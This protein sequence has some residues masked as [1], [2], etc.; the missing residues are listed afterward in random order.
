[1]IENEN[2][3]TLWTVLGFLFPAIVSIV[4]YLFWK[5]NNPARAQAIGNGLVFRVLALSGFVMILFL[6]SLL[7]ATS[8]ATPS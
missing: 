7:L 3:K 2:K 5:G 1:M 6:F 8:L 4:L